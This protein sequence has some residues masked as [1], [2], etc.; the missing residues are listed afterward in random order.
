MVD[1]DFFLGDPLLYE[2]NDFDGLTFRLNDFLGQAEQ[3]MVNCLYLNLV[4]FLVDFAA[5]S[6]A[7]C[8]DSGTGE[9]FLA[10]EVNDGPKEKAVGDHQRIEVYLQRQRIGVEAVRGGRRNLSWLSF[11]FR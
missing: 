9:V 10:R 4:E 2:F 5:S 11:A 6:K 7:G 3:R 8:L 1:E